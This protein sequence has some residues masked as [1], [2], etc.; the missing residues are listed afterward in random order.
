MKLRKG[1]DVIVIAGNDNGRTG[2]VVQVDR[3]RHRVLVSGINMRTKH[4][5]P[6]Q[7]T[8]QGERI[9]E[10][11]PIHA[12]NVMLVDPKTGKG[13]RKRPSKD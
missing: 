4:R 12:S 3:D 9:Q 2:Q 8:P 7:Q 13:A 1:D 11:V 5:K 6:T 10:E